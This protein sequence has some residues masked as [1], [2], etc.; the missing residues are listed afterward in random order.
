MTGSRP[1]EHVAYAAIAEARRGARSRTVDIPCPVC[2][3]ERTGAAARRKV[4]RTWVLDNGGYS[5]R[6]ARCDRAGWA[7]MPVRGEWWSPAST[8]STS[9]PAD[10]DDERRP[11]GDPLALWHKAVDAHGTPVERYFAERRLRLPPGADVL[12]FHPACPFAGTTTPA[13]L[14]LVRNIATN[15][16]QAI[17][18]TALDRSGNKVAI[19]GKERMALGPIK[20][21]AIKLTPD[22]HVTTALGIA[23][24]IETALSLRRLPEWRGAPVWSV[25]S[26]SGIRNFPLLSGIETLAIGTDHDRAG[27]RA[28]IELAERWQEREVLIF[29]AHERGAD[30][31]DVMRKE[32]QS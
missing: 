31:N 30:L 27:E 5:Y 26:A 24:G 12:R 20:D 29:E 21:G 14:A 4:L 10:G 17:H 32:A 3:P 9:S 18:R 16:P 8:N 22:E 6:C 25:I 13:M 19:D 11:R 15:A 1:L 23:E 28:T 7:A 2:G